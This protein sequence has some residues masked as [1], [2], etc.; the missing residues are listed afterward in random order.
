[1]KKLLSLDEILQKDDTQYREVEVPEWGG[2]VRLGSLTAG[3]M[4]EFFEKKDEGDKKTL[5]MR[6]F[7]ECLVDDSGKRI[8]DK[9]KLEAL[10]EK[11]LQVFVRLLPDMLDLNGMGTKSVPVEDAK[12]D[13]AA[14]GSGGSPTV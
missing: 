14:T 8:G 9:A 13:S 7:L 5:A 1:M 12:N 11:N 2:T 6:L 3:K 10:K 4:I